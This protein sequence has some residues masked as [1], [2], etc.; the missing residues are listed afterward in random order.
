MHGVKRRQTRKKEQ[1]KSDRFKYHKTEPAG[2]KKGADYETKCKIFVDRDEFV[3]A[4]YSN[5]LDEVD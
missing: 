1:K 3:E 5:S 4:L 2:L